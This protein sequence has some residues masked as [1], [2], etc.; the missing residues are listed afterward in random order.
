[1]IF[2]LGLFNIDITH[3]NK[4]LKG[5]PFTSYVYD[6]A[7]VKVEELPEKNNAVVHKPVSFKCMYVFL[8]LKNQSNNFCNI[9][10]VAQERWIS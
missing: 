8:L 4:H 1:M 5:S 2:N 9:F 10:S 3:F 6:A 7:N